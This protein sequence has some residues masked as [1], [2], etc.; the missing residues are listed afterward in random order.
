MAPASMHG[1]VCVCV[2]VCVHPGGGEG[3]GGDFIPS[4]QVLGLLPSVE[5]LGHNRG[6][7]WVEL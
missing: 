4:E 1:S 2:C 7:P 5:G 3:K 6:T